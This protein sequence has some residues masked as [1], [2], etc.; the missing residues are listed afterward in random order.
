MQ[1][2]NEVLRAW[3][4]PRERNAIVRLARALHRVGI[5]RHK[6]RLQKWVEQG[7]RDCKLARDLVTLAREV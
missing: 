1:T 3:G 5:E 6:T 7:E 2:M 4:L